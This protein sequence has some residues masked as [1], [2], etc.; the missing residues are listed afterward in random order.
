MTAHSARC[1]CPLR[2]TAA[3]SLSLIEPLLHSRLHVATADGRGGAT[4]HLAVFGARDRQTWTSCRRSLRGKRRLTC[5]TS[6]AAR[7][8]RYASADV[9]RAILCVR[10]W[11]VRR[12]KHGMLCCGTTAELGGGPSR[13]DREA[14]AL[15]GTPRGLSGRT[16]LLP[17]P[18]RVHP[19]SSTTRSCTHPCTPVIA[20]L[21]ALR[22]P[23]P[24]HRCNVEA[25]LVAGWRSRAP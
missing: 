6:C 5:S 21:A 14:A 8:R 11:L 18:C 12:G 10:A 25:G 20:A 16:M 13:S 4:W 22:P 19:P 7:P 9:V 24:N 3:M 2:T 15:E 1:S 23:S 17:V